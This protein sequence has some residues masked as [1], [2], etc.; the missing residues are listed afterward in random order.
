MRRTLMALV[1]LVALPIAVAPA[2]AALVV[3]VPPALVVEH[4]KNTATGVIHLHNPATTAAP[5]YLTADDFMATSTGAQLG[6]SVVFSGPAGASRGAVYEGSVPAGGSV[7]ITVE[8]ANVWEAGESLARLWNRDTQVGTLRAIKYRV[9]LAVRILDAG[10][11]PVLAFQRGVPRTV[12]LKNDDGMTYDLDWRLAIGSGVAQGHVLL[13]AD[14]VATITVAP[15]PQWFSASVAGI[16]KDETKD[17]TLTLRF[18]PKG[19]VAV[20][21]LPEQTLPVRAQ[22]AAWPAWRHPISVLVVFTALLAGGLCSLLL[23]QWFPNRLRRLDLE[24]KLADAAAR[25]RNLSFRVDSSLRILVRVERYRLLRL[26]NSRYA[27]SPEMARVLAACAEATDRLS[28][29]VGLLEQID[30]VEGDLR[31]LG[32]AVAPTLADG[33]AAR[34]RKAADRLRSPQPTDAEMQEAGALVAEATARLSALNQPDP[35]FVAALQGRLDALQSALGFSSALRKSPQS[36]KLAAP[37]RALYEY[38]DGP[39]QLTG[40]RPGEYV[41]HDLKLLRLALVHEYLRLHADIDD[42]ARARL[43]ARGGRRFAEY[44]GSPSCDSYWQARLVVREIRDDI[45]TSEVEEQILKK[46]ARIVAQPAD[47]RPHQAVEL[48]AVFTADGYNRASA[49]DEYVCQWTFEHADSDGRPTRWLETGW[50]V[51]HFF[52]KPG[53]YK[54]KATFQRKD[55]SLVA[56]QT[57]MVTVIDADVTVG[58]DNQAWFGNRT[59]IEVVRFG[60]VL[61][62]TILGLL[63]GAREQLMRLDVVAGLVA[64]FLIGFGADAVKNILVDR[65]TTPEP[66]RK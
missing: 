41:D 3:R 52:P 63:G 7:T 13:P 19:P 62:A 64:V 34:L 56:D 21:G 51:Q 17:G 60:I 4:P 47:P 22:L 42:E 66:P 11:T 48:S 27:F 12:A 65:S 45:D 38:L 15:D 26:L 30:T 49:R 59:W 20:P 58:N 36:Q 50:S 32:L 35:D 39:P 6:A 10:D 31:A 5:V 18:S 46:R 14:R 33:V 24:E 29:K 57:N 40:L 61:F 44:I 1:A 8:V 55:G 9:P 28:A 53:S 16:F 37:L 43:D 2:E 54:A 23:N 25:T